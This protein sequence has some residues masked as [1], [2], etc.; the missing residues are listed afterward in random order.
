[1]ISFRAT[2]S[3][4]LTKLSEAELVELT[5]RIADRLQV[6]RT[7]PPLSEL[8]RFSVGMVVDFTTDDGRLMRGAIARLNRETAT[9]LSTA[10]SWHVPPS[11]LR[12]P[13]GRGAPPTGE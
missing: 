12:V 1:M 9:I 5:Q 10:G 7:A 3:I 13:D 11:T 2:M 4:D 8:D 6:I